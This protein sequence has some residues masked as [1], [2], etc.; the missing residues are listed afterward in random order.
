MDRGK[1]IREHYGVEA[2]SGRKIAKLCGLRSMLISNALLLLS[3][4]RANK[5]KADQ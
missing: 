4:V 1:K 2:G 3:F 5:P